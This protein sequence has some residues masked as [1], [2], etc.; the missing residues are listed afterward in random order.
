MRFAWALRSSAS[1]RSDWRVGWSRCV[2]GW[3]GSGLWH[4]MSQVS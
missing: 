1:V 4:G 3:P 2:S